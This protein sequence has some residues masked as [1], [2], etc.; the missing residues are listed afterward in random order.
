M[1]QCSKCKEI[2]NYEEFSNDK[3]K[4]DGKYPS[5]KICKHKNDLLYKKNNKEKIQEKDKH[6][7][8]K[9]SDKIKERSK[10]W[11][12]N[13]KEHCKEI[14][15]NWYIKNFE[16]VK[17]LRK[18]YKDQDK[19]KWDEYMKKYQCNRYRT[20]LQ[21]KIKSI[22]NSRI[23]DYTKQKVM[24]TLDFL[25]C[26]MDFFIKWIEYQFDTN[27]SW[28][29]IGKYWHFD[30][31][32]P[33]VLFDLTNKDEQLICYHWSNI[34]PCEKIENI[35]KKDKIIP[36]LILKQEKLAYNFNSIFV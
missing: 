14:K 15:K 13:N 34:R 33:C 35:V 24:K 10:N 8:N 5:C 31:V 20:N 16:K 32:L 7:Y 18:A 12:N 21:Y 17:I 28:E 4:K 19:K 6:Y 23:R 11:Y 1:K 25:G 9:N 3:S 29:N 2:K 22:L 26:S 27:M 36:D 30:H